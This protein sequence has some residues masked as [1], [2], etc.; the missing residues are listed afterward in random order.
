VKETPNRGYPYPE[1]DD[2]YVKDTADL[3]YDL[4]LL[5]TAIDADVTSV[6]ATASAVLNPPCTSISASPST[7]DTF[8][9]RLTMT[10]VDFDNASQASLPA[11][12]MFAATDGLYH[13]MAKRSYSQSA[14]A[15]TQVLIKVNGLI[16][17]LVS[18]SPVAAASTIAMT[19]VSVQILNAGDY[20][21]A[22]SVEQNNTA[23]GSARVQ[24]HRVL[25]L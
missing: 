10:A 11:S 4:K 8:N 15:G 21:T 18:I 2:P 7:Q 17:D 23:D 3:P 12:G 5:A 25:A 24:M 1:C 20:V 6:A 14:S 19:A 13:I 22:Y 16:V 9:L